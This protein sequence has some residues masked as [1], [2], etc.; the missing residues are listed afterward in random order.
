MASATYL[1]HGLPSI[2]ARGTVSF[3]RPI[4]QHFILFPYAVGLA[5][6]CGHAL[7]IASA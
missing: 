4:P 1:L 2:K 3:V 6:S 5:L 7:A